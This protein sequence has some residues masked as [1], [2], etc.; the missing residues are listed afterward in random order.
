M[1][2]GRET[3]RCH[4]LRVSHGELEIIPSY[5]ILSSEREPPTKEVCLFLDEF[6]YCRFELSSFRWRVIEKGTQGNV[7]SRVVIL[8]HEWILSLRALYRSFP[9]LE[10]E[11]MSTVNELPYVTLR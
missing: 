3:E 6:V 8:R 4:V 10:H 2:R 11:R 5:S 9:K 7:A 1:K